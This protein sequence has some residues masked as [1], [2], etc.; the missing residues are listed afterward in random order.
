MNQPLLLSM[1]GNDAMADQLASELGIERGRA[2][3]RRFPDGESYVRVESMV[4]GRSVCI[5]CTLDRPDAKLVPLLLLAA[6]A[7]ETGASKVGLV[8][9]YLAYMRQDARFHSGEVVSARHIAAWLSGCFDWVVTVDPHLHRLSTLSDVFTVPTRNVHAADAIASW[10]RGNVS[11]PVL[12][13]PDAESAQWVDDVARRAQAPST[14]LR[15]TRHGDRD[16]EV[17]VPDVDRWRGHTPVL[18]DDI[19]STG[20]TLAA[21]ISQLRRALIQAPVCIAVHAVFAGRAE[22][23]LLSAGAQ[24]VV[25]CDTI[26]HSSNGIAIGGALALAVREMLTLV[27]SEP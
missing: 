25:S 3:V 20:H 23:R 24:R 27:R 12:L 13:G 9:P 19:A 7:R 5:V 26:A 18:V 10:L 2:T 4:D 11:R 22:Q 6:A 17:S 1:P 16:V 15:K 8:A 14:V 21:A